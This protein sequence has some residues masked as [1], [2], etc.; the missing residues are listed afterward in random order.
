LLS[1][2]QKTDFFIALLLEHLS[3]KRMDKFE[4][5]TDKRCIEHYLGFHLLSWSKEVREKLDLTIWGG[6]NKPDAKSERYM[7][8]EKI[9][10]T[11]ALLPMYKKS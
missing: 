10:Q 1:T 6:A 8:P 4:Y 9:L 2:I 3:K 5:N 11:M 7:N